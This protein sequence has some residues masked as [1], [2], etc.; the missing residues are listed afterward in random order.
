MN[1]RLWKI[2]LP[3]LLAGAFFLIPAPAGLKLPAWHLFG[4]FVATIFALILQSM[5][6]AA[7]LI[8][9]LAAAGLF[10]VPM[11]SVL[12]GYT[13]GT[14]WIIVVAIM[15]SLGFRKSGLA[16]RIGLILIKKFGRTSLRIGYI[17]SFMDLL[18]ATSTPAAPARGGGLVYPLAEGVIDVCGSTPTNGPRK[19][20]AYLT[21][22]EYMICMTTGSIFLT[23]MGPNLFN[24]RLAQQM[25]GIHVTWPLWAMAALP[26]FI[27]FLII[28]W[29]VYK[30][31]P[32]ELSSLATVQQA[33]VSELQAMGSVSRKEWITG[34][35]FLLILGLWATGTATKINATLV[36]F[37]G[38]SLMLLFDIIQWKDIA[39][40]KEAWSILIWFGAILGL[41]AALG[42]TGFF[43]WLAAFLKAI[44]PTAGLG[45][46]AILL[47]VALLA[48]VPHY[49]FASLVGYVAAF[50]PLAF[51]FI[52]ATDVPHFP[53]FFL[54]AYLMVIS[55]TLT[56]YGNG[57]GPL[58]Y[59]KGFT[60]K[61]TWWLIGLMVTALQVVLY[62]TV[63]PLWW[64]FLGVWY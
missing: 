20:G 11:G 48:T 16:R 61:K 58:L 54:V 29:L 55:S 44:L 8:I 53:A 5:P 14:L 63:G 36:A 12:V 27:G 33:T 34:G 46:Y 7:V 47:V 59:A 3:I 57:L 18:L 60:D 49:I 41:S 28:P 30:V 62:L 24:V 64:K 13:D 10:A 40:S 37:L 32:P 42:K 4:I 17:I 6:E 19:I 23:G 2:F 51:S 1:E 31:Y 22:L 45:Q 25:L 21:V 9:S 39:E 26:G 50:A 56:H 38:V 43:T 35:I 52:L 15:F